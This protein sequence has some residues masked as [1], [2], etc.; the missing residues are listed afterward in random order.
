MSEAMEFLRR[1][2]GSRRMLAC[3]VPLGS[4]F[5]WA[6]YCRIGGDVHLAWEHRLL[7]WLRHRERVSTFASL[8][9]TL[10]R[11]QLNGRAFQNDPD[12]FIL[13]ETGQQL[14]AT[15]QHTVLIINILLG[16]LH[17]TSDDVVAY[18]TE[19]MTELEGALLWQGSQVLAV[20]EVE[21][22]VFAID[23]LQDNERFRAYCNLTR[24]EQFV[25]FAGDKNANGRIGIQPFETL[26]LRGS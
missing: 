25:P 3:G 5:G 18:T 8:R 14:T 23:F 17:F 19:Q 11:W 24:K 21:D 15:Q 12:V 16:N 1:Q 26:L 2:I 6:D 7:A 22:D 4:C 9:A 10:G 13:R 20:K